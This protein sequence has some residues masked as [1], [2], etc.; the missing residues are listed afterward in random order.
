MTDRSRQVVATVGGRTRIGRVVANTGRDLLVMIDQAE[1]ARS[2]LRLGD[3]LVITANGSAT[4]GVVSGMNIPAPGLDNEGEA[5]WLAQVE[6]SGTMEFESEDSVFTRSINHSPSLGDVVHRASTTDL[7]RLFRNGAERSY[8]I[9][10]IMDAENVSATIDGDALIEGGFAIVGADACG[11]SSTMASIVRALL[12]HRHPVKMVL[13]DPNN[14]YSQSF[15][16]AART[17]RPKSGTFPHWLLSYEE[18]IWVLSTQGGELSEEEKSILEDILPVAK[19]RFFARAHR[20]RGFGPEMVSVDVPIPYRVTD[21]ISILDKNLTTDDMRSRPAYQRLR[22]RIMSASGDPR[23][24][25]FFGTV[26]ATDTLGSLF[27]DLFSLEKGGPPMSV[28]QLA[29]LPNGIDKIIVSIICRMAAAFTAWGGIEEQV[30]VLIDEAE[31]FAPHSSSHPA[32][33]LCLN[34]IRTLGERS[35]KSGAGI[36]LVTSHPRTVCREV[37]EKQGSFF[38]HRMPGQAEID[39]LED[40]MPEAATTFMGHISNLGQ[41][42][43][44]AM[45]R[46]VP[47]A[48]RIA[49]SPLPDN[50]I[51]REE[52]LQSTEQNMD[53]T[54]DTLVRRWRFNGIEVDDSDLDQA[55]PETAARNPSSKPA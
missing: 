42:E 7:Q 16:K 45:G 41:A 24:S 36:G 47:L 18:L 2:T 35:K 32:M 39:L 20:P 5:I 48:G 31:R 9:G 55:E 40:V 8:P 23:L 15:G 26:T 1:E 12:R 21:I 6:L 4:I 34:A 14:E 44:I 54:I 38:V 46:A 28:I 13:I 51:P 22:T 19:H 30:L 33:T 3:M 37:L 52:R 27:S 53:S 17:V 43:L 10:T 50:A 29:S 25:V 11:K 49:I